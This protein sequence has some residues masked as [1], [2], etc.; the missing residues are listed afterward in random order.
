MGHHCG[1]IVVCWFA[2]NEFPSSGFRI[3]SGQDALEPFLAAFQDS[4]RD[5]GQAIPRWRVRQPAAT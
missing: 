4:V 5:Q 3:F 1:G 2:M